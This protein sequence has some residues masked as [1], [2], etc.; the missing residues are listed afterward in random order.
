MTGMIWRII[1]L[2]NQHDR[3]GASG[4]ETALTAKSTCLDKRALPPLSRKDCRDQDRKNPLSAQ[5]PESGRYGRGT[6]R[7]SQEP[8]CCAKSRPGNA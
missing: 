3:C 4:D 8:R 2:S 5:A 1:A 7:R 6:N